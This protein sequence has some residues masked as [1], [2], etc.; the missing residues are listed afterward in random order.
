MSNYEIKTIKLENLRL[1]LENPRYDHQ[2]GQREAL[3]AYL[4]GNDGV[5]LIRLAESIASDGLNP[6]ELPMVTATDHSNIYTVLEGNRRVASLKLASSPH[7]IDSF[8]VSPKLKA[9]FKALHTA[10]LP[11]ELVCAVLPEE[12]ARE[13]IN[14]KHTGENRGIGIVGWDGIAKQRFRGASPSLQAIDLV[15]ASRYIDVDTREKLSTIAITTIERFLGTPDA[16]KEI[17][18][19]V[20]NGHLTLEA[21]DGG[22]IEDAALQ[23]L[24]LIVADVAHR[25][26]RVPHLDSKAQRVEYAKHIAS[27]PLSTLNAVMGEDNHHSDKTDDLLIATSNGTNNIALEHTSNSGGGS[28]GSSPIPIVPSPAKSPQK[29]NPQRNTLIPSRLK[30]TIPHSRINQ[31][32]HEL[33]KLK[34]DEFIHSASVMLRV[35]VEQSMDEFCKSHGIDLNRPLGTYKAPPVPSS[36]TVSSTPHQAKF[37]SV[38]EKATE[39]C[40]YMERNGVDATETYGM[41]AL[42]SNKNHILSVESLHAYVH[43]PNYSPT[44]SDLKANWDSIQVFIERLWT[45]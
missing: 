42:C 31:I 23:R 45:I 16:C 6:S 22:N 21:R 12:D 14:L 38:Q 15:S 3:K 32:Y 19:S 17:G 4:S 25:R 30:L 29:I 33:Q 36:T 27:Q 35:F 8:T 44:A 28:N 34:L 37:K 40:E 41:R 1:N 24:A 43:N 39:I 26:I 9:R 10:S 11:L 20:K 7:L 5:K 18:V 13:W 2:V